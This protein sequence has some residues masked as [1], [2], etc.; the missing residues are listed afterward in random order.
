MIANTGIFGKHFDGDIN[1]I[2]FDELIPYQ[3]EYDKIVSPQKAPPGNHYTEAELSPLG[4]LQDIAEG[5]AVTFDLPVEG[6]EKTIYYTQSGLGFQV[7]KQMVRDDLFKN[8]QRMPRKLA[9]SAAY[10][11]ETEFFELFN[12]AFV[13]TYHTAWD[14]LALCTSHTTLKSLD[15]ID[16]DLTPAALSETSL[17]AMFEYYDNLVDEAGMPAVMNPWKLV[18]GVANRW[19]VG[20]LQ[21]QQFNIG[22]DDRDV[23]STNPSNGLVAPWEPHLSRHMVDDDRFFL[24]AREHDMRYYWKEEAQLDSADDFFTGNALFKVIMEFACFTMD[25]RGI[26]GNPGV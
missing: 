11:R 19:V 20:R 2:F 15:T 22:S 23:M 9:K 21:K 14:G 12:T 18:T 25:Y 13:A 16:N 3:T 7:T 4:Q 17:Q 10:K 1:D 24:V 5:A 26:C 8:F 6:H